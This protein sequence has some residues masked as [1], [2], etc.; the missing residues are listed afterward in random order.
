MPGR[1]HRQWGRMVELPLLVALAGISI[2]IGLGQKSWIVGIAVFFAIPVGLFAVFWGWQAIYVE[3]ILAKARLYLRLP[4][5]RRAAVTLLYESAYLVGDAAW[6]VGRA[7]ALLRSALA[8]AE[9]EVRLFAASALTRIGRH[10]EDCMPVLIEALGD[11]ERRGE[12]FD[13]MRQLG[14]KAQTA[15]PALVALAARREASDWWRVAYTLEAIGPAASAAVPVLIASLD[16]ISVDEAGWPIRALGAIGDASALP[17][18]RRM[19]KEGKDERVRGQASAAIERIEA[20][21]K[22]Q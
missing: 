20:G 13:A 5:K 11:E 16:G 7:S 15:V 14:P 2:A 21:T 12:A 10:A 4:Q 19:A 8:D 17:A 1:P 22:Q 18:L 9:P 3:W 6:A